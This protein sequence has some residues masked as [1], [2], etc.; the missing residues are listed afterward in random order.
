MKTYCKYDELVVVTDL[1][2][3]PKNRNQ[4]PPEQI[5]R[6]AKILRY[7]G[8]RA[9]IVVSKRS[10]HIVKGHGTLLAISKNGWTTAPVVYQD[11]DSDEQ[12]YA[13]LQSDNAIAD[14]AQ[15]D[16]SGINLDLPELG[17]DFDIEMLGLKNFTL[18]PSE[19][20]TEPDEK[21][22][23]KKRDVDLTTCPNCGVLLDNG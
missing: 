4:H 5:D 6:L 2:P 21:E 15:L 10:N 23:P 14:W 17:P 20:F 13:F 8:V 16:L 1:I 19:D 18:D 3:H 11:F 9:P 12:E 7:Q 22:D